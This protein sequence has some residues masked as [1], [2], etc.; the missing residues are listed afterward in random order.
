MSILNQ[1]R[2]GPESSK[3]LTRERIHAVVQEVE[4]RLKRDV[5][6][7]RIAQALRDTPC[8][9][10]WLLGIVLVLACCGLFL[11]PAHTTID[12]ANYE[13]LD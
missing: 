5:Q 4:K 9:I 3:P 7:R 2:P 12:E 11:V 10:V 13:V 1:L 8:V 6:R